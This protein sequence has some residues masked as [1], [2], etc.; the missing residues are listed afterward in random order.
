[1]EILLSTDEELPMCSSLLYL[2]FLNFWSAQQMGIA[3]EF[4]KFNC[5]FYSAGVGFFFS[6]GPPKELEK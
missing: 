1:V 5:F 4:S 6:V 3:A 2:S